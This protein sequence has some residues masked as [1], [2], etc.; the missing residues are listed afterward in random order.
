MKIAEVRFLEEREQLSLPGWTNILTKKLREKYILSKKPYTIYEKDDTLFGVLSTVPGQ[1]LPTPWRGKAE[2]L[3]KTLAAEGAGIIVGP[4]EGEFPQKI[5]PVAN[6]RILAALFAFDGAAEALR[7]QGK[8]PEEAHYVISGTDPQV[9]PLVLAGMGDYVNHLSFFADNTG[10]LEEIQEE[11]FAEKGL[12]TEV[13]SSPKNPLFSEG[14]GIIVCGMEQTGY[15]H[16]LKR[17]AVFIDAA[18]NRPTLRRLSQRRWDVVAAEGFYFILDGKQLEGRR[19]EAEAF[20]N[21]MSFQNFWLDHFPKMQAEEI[22][23]DLKE[24]G[25][26]VSGFSTLGKRVKI[27]KNQG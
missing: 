12:L 5:L 15:E 8:N 4:H 18:G 14:D 22:Y 27:P 9:L 1:G 2:A 11:L 23:F 13:F 17:Y 26:C 24:K 19:A 7:R 21:C 10:E 25:F 20:I 6:G 3:I 16:I